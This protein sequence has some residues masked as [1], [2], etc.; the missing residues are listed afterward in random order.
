MMFSLI[1]YDGTPEG[2]SA[3]LVS[4]DHFT[5]ANGYDATDMRQVVRL[6]LGETLGLDFGVVVVR[7]A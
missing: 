1:T 2:F 4:S 3:R 7:I 5:P 6:A